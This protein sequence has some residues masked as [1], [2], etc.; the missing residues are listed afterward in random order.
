VYLEVAVQEALYVSGAELKGFVELKGSL[1]NFAAPGME[2]ANDVALS[3]K[4]LYRCSLQG[5]RIGGKFD[6]RQSQF[7]QG[8]VLNLSNCEVHQAMDFADP[9][10]TPV[11]VNH[12]SLSCYPGFSLT[13]VLFVDQGR[14]AIAAYL[15]FDRQSDV[16]ES[17]YLPILL[18]G[19]SEHLRTLNAGY[20]KLAT[21]H[22]SREKTIRISSPLTLDTEDQAR[23]YLRLFCAYVWGEYG[24]FSLI[25]DPRDLPASATPDP[26]IL[27]IPCVEIRNDEGKDVWE[28][29]AYVR[30]SEEAFIATFHVFKDM[31]PVWMKDD[32]P[33]GRYE[34]QERALLSAFDAPYRI[35]PVPNGDTAQLIAS[36]RSDF[37][38]WTK[39]SSGAADIARFKQEAMWWQTLLQ[40]FAGV[41]VN[42]NGASCRLLK[43]NAAF[44]WKRIGKLEVESFDY[45][46]VFIPKS[47]DPLD[48]VGTRLDMVRGNLERP[49]TM[50]QSVGYFLLT[51]LSLPVFPVIMFLIARRWRWQPSAFRAKPYTHLAQVL[52][53][54]GDDEAAREVEAEKIWQGAVDRGNSTRWGKL[55]EIYWWRPYGVMFRYGL[56]PLCAA[57]SVLAIWVLG[58]V[59][60]SVLSD[61][62][63]L[64]AAVTKVAP[65]AQVSPGQPTIVALQGTP[66]MI[67]DLPCG[68]EIEPG[69]YSFELLTP[70]LNLHQES[71]CG[72]RADPYAEGGPKLFKRQW[73]SLAFLTHAT[74]WEYAKA[75]YMLVG[76]VIS[77]LALL[78]FSGIARRWEH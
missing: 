5:A 48:E 50:R 49:E 23:E 68:A 34:G 41:L 38:G 67:P 76:S 2:T 69:L 25:T 71:R 44:L 6:L 72:L 65:A 30:Y 45:K 60:V 39:F 11:A 22:G 53:E 55:S 15:T 37:Y 40:G 43:D 29:R 54:R 63:M 14:H 70:I 17:T 66:G 62:H 59:A 4:G 27:K 13:E 8:A 36:Y 16:P 32:E 35:I 9:V 31:S 56:S 58:W 78:T 47:P 52:R 74:F 28:V 12:S 46:Q 24:S 26:E 42:L 7:R 51:I 21:H 77:S 20:L 3:F 10:G 19:R 33:F 73:H 61:H 18:N 57:A 64:Q 75:L 1:P